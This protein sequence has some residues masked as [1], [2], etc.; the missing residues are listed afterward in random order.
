MRFEFIHAERANFP[1]TLMCRILEVSTSGYYRWRNAPLSKR[2]QE[3]ARLKPKIAAAFAE[4]RETYGSPRI[5]AELLD[6]GVKVGLH[7]IT[8]LMHEMGLS[9]MPE[10]RFQFTTNS[11][12]RLGFAP[13]LVEREFN[14]T[15]PNRLWVSDITYIWT[16]DGWLYLA[17]VLDM[18]SRRVVGWAV[19]DH[20]RDELVLDALR[21]AL[22]LREVDGELV[23]HSDRGGQYASK[24]FRTL[25]DANGIA[26]SMGATGCCYD[27]AAAES[28]FATLKKDLVHRCRYR[29]LVAAKSSISEYIN[30]FYNSRRR[31]SSL[32]YVSPIDFEAAHRQQEPEAALAA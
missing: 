23:H 32:G 15:A 10:R 22:T 29:D 1:I 27:N 21:R 13:D 5:H 17:V 3:D 14:P 4:S 6:R 7:R 24:D 12:H 16:D 26:W 20:M 28:F 9:A 19:D 30:L 8:R 2:A 18:F 11:K 31:H 25:L